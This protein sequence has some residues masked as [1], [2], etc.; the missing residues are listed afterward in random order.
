MRGLAAVSAVLA[1]AGGIV[2]CTGG[3]PDGAAADLVLR[4]GTVITVDS[5]D[6]IAE[7]VAVKDGRVVAVGSNTEVNRFVGTG[8]ETVDL[9]GRTVTPGLIDA[10]AHFGWGGADRLFVLDLSYPNVETMADVVAKVSVTPRVG[11]PES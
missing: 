1:F 6:R 4:G 9:G 8:T 11:Q 10:H 3:V 7:A 5:N 2:G